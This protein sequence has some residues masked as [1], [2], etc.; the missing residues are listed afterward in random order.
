MNKL[1]ILVA[2]IGC[3]TEEKKQSPTG[4]LHEKNTA[5]ILERAVEKMP[6]MSL[7]FTRMRDDGWRKVDVK[8]GGKTYTFHDDQSRYMLDVQGEGFGD[9][10]ILCGMSTPDP[11][12]G[13]NMQINCALAESRGVSSFVNIATPTSAWLSDVCIDD[14]GKPSEKVTLLYSSGTNFIDPNVPLDQP[15]CLSQSWTA[16]GGWEET[17]T[18]SATCSCSQ[19]AGQSCTDA[20]FVGTGV[21]DT[22]G[23]CDTSKL[24]KA[25]DDGNPATDDFC[26]GDLNQLCYSVPRI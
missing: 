12:D 22:E 9:R 26:T 10:A 7:V 13:T 15:S 24:I 2:L 5:K 20:C 25:C 1:F 8:V 3:G 23:A 11:H 4:E 6:G 16:A 17:A 18:P 21:R 19:R 14:A